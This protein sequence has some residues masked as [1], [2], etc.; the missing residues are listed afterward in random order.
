[1]STDGSARAC[2]VGVCPRLVPTLGDPGEASGPRTDG[3]HRLDSPRTPGASGARGREDPSW[4]AA[5]ACL[6]GG[7]LSKTKP[8]DTG[9]RRLQDS[10]GAASAHPAPRTQK[11]TVFTPQFSPYRSLWTMNEP[12]GPQTLLFGACGA[13]QNASVVNFFWV[14]TLSNPWGTGESR[15]RTFIS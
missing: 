2:G 1:M 12:N 14:R 4:V 10:T 8:G 6:W 13:Q 9:P 5:M 11:I 7:V 3:F 15:A